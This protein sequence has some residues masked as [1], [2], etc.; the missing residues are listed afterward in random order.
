MEHL[1]HKTSARGSRT[2]IRNV[3]EYLGVHGSR[4]KQ[5]GDDEC[6]PVHPRIPWLGHNHANSSFFRAQVTS[7]ELVEE[8]FRD[9]CGPDWDLERALEEKDLEM[10][11][12]MGDDGRYSVSRVGTVAF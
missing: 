10:H 11:I 3:V 8:I 4:L 9:Y 1:I 5:D 7:D 6:P 12:E 2:E